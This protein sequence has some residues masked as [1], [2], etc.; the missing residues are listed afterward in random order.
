[1]LILKTNKQTKLLGS[2]QLLKKTI[3]RIQKSDKEHEQ[4]L[5]VMQSDVIVDHVLIL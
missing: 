1:M 2:Q 4:N 5:E 3:I